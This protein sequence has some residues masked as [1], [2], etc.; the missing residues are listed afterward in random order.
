MIYFIFGLIVGWILHS[1]LS[2]KKYG[3]R[4]N[5]AEKKAWE[6]LPREERIN[7]RIEKLRLLMPNLDDSQLQE[8]ALT[9]D[10][11]EFPNK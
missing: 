8:F 9:H 10:W 11:E 1:I 2:W 4:L 7:I 3:K 6:L 5:Y